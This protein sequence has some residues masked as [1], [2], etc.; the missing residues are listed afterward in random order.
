MACQETSLAKNIEFE[1][2]NIFHEERN[3]TTK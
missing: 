1:V 2:G 3:N